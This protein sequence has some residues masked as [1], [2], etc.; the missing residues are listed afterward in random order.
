MFGVATT[1]ELAFV[2][3]LLLMVLIAPKIPR[4]GEAIGRALGGRTPADPRP[5]SVPPPADPPPA[6]EG[7]PDG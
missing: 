7:E 6:R 4:V 2:A 3:M 1:S 5:R